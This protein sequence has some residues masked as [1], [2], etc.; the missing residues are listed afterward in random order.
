MSKLTK[1]KEKMKK[2][3]INELP[4][5]DEFREMVEGH[6]GDLLSLLF[7]RRKLIDKYPLVC[8]ERDL[9][10]GADPYFKEWIGL[11]VKLQMHDSP[12]GGLYVEF[13]NIPKELMNLFMYQDYAM[14]Y[15]EIVVDDFQDLLNELIE[16]YSLNEIPAEYTDVIIMG[17]FWMDT[18]E[19]D[20]WFAT[21]DEG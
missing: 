16:I 14:K 20:N 5:P 7:M 17:A 2:D 15:D 13:H 8:E 3:L 9:I 11:D 1:M 6:M 21:F 10:T 4:H 12:A 19:C 18:D